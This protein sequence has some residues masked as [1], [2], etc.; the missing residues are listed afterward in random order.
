[1]GQRNGFLIDAHRSIELAMM[2]E[3]TK[4][5]EELDWL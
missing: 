2:P 5:I 4:A 3:I 1:M